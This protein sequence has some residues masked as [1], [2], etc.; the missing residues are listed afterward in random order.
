MVFSFPLPRF[1][2]AILAV[3]FGLALP[4]SAQ[5]V[6][7]KGKESRL[8]I[9]GTLISAEGGKFLVKTAM[10]EFEIDRKLVTCEGPG[11]P[12]KR[13]PAYDLDLAAEGD[14]ARVLIPVIAQGFAATLDAESAPTDA[15]GTP[16]EPEAAGPGE[17]G[18]AYIGIVDFNGEA[19]AHLGI[20]EAEGMAAFEALAAGEASILFQKEGVSRKAR[21]LLESAGL[22]KLDSPEQDRVIALEGYAVVVN[23]KNSVG[24]VTI[25]QVGDILSGR[26]TDWAELGGTPGP[27][28]VYSLAGGTGAFGSV[29]E[30]LLA[31]RGGEQAAAARI[32]TL[33]PSARI[34]DGSGELTDAV[35]NDEAGFGVVSYQRRNET[36][37][38]P[39][40]NECGMTFYVSPF[41]IKTEEYPLARRMHVYSGRNPADPEQAFL[42]YLGGPEIDGLVAEAGFIDLDVVPEIQ[43]DAA[44]RVAVAAAAES[45]PYEKRLMETLIEKQGL[46]ERL[47]TTFRFAQGSDDLDPRGQR[48]LARLIGFLKERRPAEVIA[49]GF[50]DDK[51]RFDANLFVGEQRAADVIREIR[52]AAAEGELEGVSLSALGFGELAPVACNTNQRGRASNRRV[53]I[54]IR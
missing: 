20:L 3:S 35:M 8:N 36:R 15:G 31:N 41:T 48:D 34:V 22:G 4:A 23:P 21:D 9:S 10:G 11:C 43:I 18:R 30:L 7:L 49:V 28:N 38:L 37:A 54:W 17:D 29:S 39:L 2:T 12:Q 40:T 46:Y 26:I 1:T 33:A 25:G 50:T 52:A 5:E 24:A 42:D 32:I 16:V 51:G 44:D 45:D 14:I 19:V 6:V 53:E 47:S 27:I 13:E